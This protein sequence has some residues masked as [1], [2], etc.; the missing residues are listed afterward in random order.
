MVMAVLAGLSVMAQ[1][2]GMLCKSDISYI[3]PSDK[4]SYRQEK[5]KLDVWYPENAQDSQV[6]VWLH[7]GGLT[8]GEK[9]FPNEF[10]GQNI[11]VVSVNYRLSPEAECP[12]YIEDAAEAVAWVVKNIKSFGGDPRKINVSGHSAG[13]YL[14][15]MLCLDKSYLQKHGIDADSIEGYYPVS[16]ESITH[17]TVRGENNIPYLTRL[18]DKYAP[19]YHSRKIGAKLALFTG[20]RK[21]EL[22]ARCEENIYLK[23]ALERD[24][25]EKIPMFEFEGFDHNTCV[26]PA[27]LLIL[28]HMNGSDPQTVFKETIFT[29]S[30][31]VRARYETLVDIPYVSEDEPSGYRKERCLLDI[32]YP[33]DQKNCKVLVWFHGG[34]LKSGIKE[35]PEAMMY[36]DVVVVS[37]DYRFSPEVKAP[38]YIEDAA[39]AVAWVHKHI[40][41]YNGNPDDIFVS[42][43]SAGGYLTLMLA[44]DKHYLADAG[45]DAD[46]ISGYI[47]LTG[48]TSRHTALNDEAGLDEHYKVVA[49]ELSPLAN[50]RNCTPPVWLITGER[51]I[52][53]PTRY[54]QNLYLYAVLKSMGKENVS[55]YGISGYGHGGA[56]YEGSMIMRRILDFTPAK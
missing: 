15:L 18:I 39:A 13:G 43:A 52:D 7:G 10:A 5:C 37:V 32:H 14:T 16:G 42:G 8:G 49:D 22:P 38:A 6:L 40:A 31:A 9:Y 28:K 51:G 25:N 45:Y 33:K 24:G 53:R 55:H 1:S 36:G 20:D 2:R 17:F 54:A 50:A 44:M 35:I 11:I 48:Q 4:S 41:E 21:L 46:K 12:A 27:S 23:D 29:Q 30:E 56:G 34:G 26:H 3:S 47:S 19:I